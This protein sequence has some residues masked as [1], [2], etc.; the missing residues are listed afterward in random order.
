MP[1]TI[2]SP[3]DRFATYFTI[4]KTVPLHMIS[5]GPQSLSHEEIAADLAI[6]RAPPQRLPSTVAAA[7]ARPTPPVP[8]KRVR[9][10]E[11][12]ADES[13]AS[14]AKRQHS[15]AEGNMQVEVQ[16]NAEPPAWVQTLFAA[17]TLNEAKGVL[18]NAGYRRAADDASRPQ[19]KAL[20]AAV[21]SAIQQENK[22]VL[23]ATWLFST[24]SEFVSAAQEACNT[25]GSKVSDP[26]KAYVFQHLLQPG[27][28]GAA[29]FKMANRVFSEAEQNRL[30]LF[31]L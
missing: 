29:Q 27:R 20:Q 31:A 3:R 22:T 25:P 11:G 4:P 10:A 13:P 18:S 9:A 5:P 30:A 12:A 8:K 16:A 7:S 19:D 6:F 24:W 28:K 17:K 2:I 21:V 15:A 1:T 26:M 23:A 14:N